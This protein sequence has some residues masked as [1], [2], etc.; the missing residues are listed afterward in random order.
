MANASAL[1]RHYPSALPN[2]FI[3]SICLHTIDVSGQSR[4]LIA[5]LVDQTDNDFDDIRI[6]LIFGRLYTVYIA[7]K[8]R[9]ALATFFVNTHHTRVE[10]ARD[11]VAALDKPRQ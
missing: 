4:E 7:V 11:S 8:P 10:Q 5:V 2:V 3:G 6:R 1:P 9:R